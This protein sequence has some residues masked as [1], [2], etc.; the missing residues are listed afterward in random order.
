MLEKILAERLDIDA[1]SVSDEKNIVEDLGADSLSVVEIIMDIE[2]E[3]D[4]NI[5]DEDAEE[6]HTVGQLREYIENYA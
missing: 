1:D 4:I 5:P 6:L 3:F 2:N